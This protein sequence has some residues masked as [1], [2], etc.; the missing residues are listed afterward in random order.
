M[1]DGSY[2]PAYAL[3]DGRLERAGRSVQSKANNSCPP[4]AAQSSHD[5]SIG[6]SYARTAALLVI[7]DELLSGK[8]WDDAVINM[9][10]V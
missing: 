9:V 2:A 10:P 5:A 6:S 4:D 3:P 7:G 8:V 1:E